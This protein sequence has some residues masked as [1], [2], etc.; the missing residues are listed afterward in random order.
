MLCVNSTR[1]MF[2]NI[3]K[4]TSSV[5]LRDFQYRLLHNKIFCND[6]LFYWKKLTSNCCDFCD[7][8][9]SI[10]H[11]M[12]ECPIVRPIWMRLQAAFWKAEIECNINKATVIFNQ[13]HENHT[14]IC[15]TVALIVKQFIYRCKCQNKAPNFNEVI[16]EIRLNYKIDLYNN[17]S[18]SSKVKERWS[19]VKMVIKES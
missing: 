3:T 4:L 11:L 18:D 9:Q 12:F 17:F 6:Q 2:K 8:K 14:H 16:H 19:P 13:I 10:V 5:K 15:N 7:T 1:F